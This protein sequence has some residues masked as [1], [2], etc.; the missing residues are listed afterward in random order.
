MKTLIL[1]FALMFLMVQT[2]VWGQTAPKDGD[3][4]SA[5]DLDRVKV[6]Q[7]APDFTLEDSDGK[8]VSLEDYRGKKN[9]VLVFYRGHW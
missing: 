1:L 6:G 8:N 3:R 7:P 9:V 4:Q 2:P 5:T